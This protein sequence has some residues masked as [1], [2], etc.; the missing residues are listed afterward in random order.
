M[1]SIST[2]QRASEQHTHLDLFHAAR[3]QPA[4]RVAR[5]QAPQQRLGSR[6]EVAVVIRHLQVQCCLVHALRARV[7][8]G[9]GAVVG[10]MAQWGGR[11][12]THLV[13]VGVQR[14]RGLGAERALAVKHLVHHAAVRP[15]VDRKAVRLPAAI[16][17]DQHLGRPVCASSA[18]WWEVMIPVGWWTNKE[19]VPPPQS[20]R[21]STRAAAAA[22]GWRH[23]GGQP[24]VADA[25]IAGVVQQ[26][27]LGL[28]RCVVRYALA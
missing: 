10:L 3:P 8:V 20:A 27:V 2:G 16:H 17:S 9:G 1:Y 22:E 6:R 26:D 24:K 14:P 11:P 5:Q 13:L 15:K 19:S 18:G 12:P 28:Q 21:T 25:R 7:F 4:R 23:M